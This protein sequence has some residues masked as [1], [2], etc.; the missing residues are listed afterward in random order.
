MLA[1]AKAQVL[2]GRERPEAPGT[3][4]SAEGTWEGSEG[5]HRQALSL[6]PGPGSG[7]RPILC[8]GEG[9]FWAPLLWPKN[10]T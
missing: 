2:T 7:P 1:V 3:E 5:A 4:T 10:H 6:A 8:H 9:G